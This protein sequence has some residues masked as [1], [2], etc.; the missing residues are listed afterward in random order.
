MKYSREKTFGPTK[1]PQEKLSNPQNTHKK[2]FRTH[3]APA[4][5]TFESTKCTQEK[6]LD[7]RNTYKK[8]FGPMTAQ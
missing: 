6:L 4:R 8:T 3:E 7:P 5:K 2:N 1:H